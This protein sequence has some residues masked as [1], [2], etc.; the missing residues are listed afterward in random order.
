MVATLR[1][2]QVREDSETY[3][4]DIEPY[5]RRG[6]SFEVCVVNNVKIIPREINARQFYRW[7]TDTHCMIFPAI[8]P[9]HPL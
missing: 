9:H 8:L 6:K 2:P 1:I 7:S 4:V 5:L 3:H